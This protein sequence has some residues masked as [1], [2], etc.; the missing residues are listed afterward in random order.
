MKRLVVVLVVA[1][2][3][4]LSSAVMA[5]NSTTHTATTN[6]LGVAST[7]DKACGNPS[8]NRIPMQIPVFP[9]KFCQ[10]M[11]IFPN[12]VTIVGGDSKAQARADGAIKAVLQKWAYPCN[13]SV[14]GGVKPPA[15]SAK[16]SVTLVTD[17]GQSTSTDNH[18]GSDGWS[19][20][21]YRSGSSSHYDSASSSTMGE[22]TF[23]GTS[24]SG[25]LSLVE[26]DGSTIGL[27]MVGDVFSANVERTGSASQ[28]SSSHSYSSSWRRGSDSYHR[29]SSSGSSFRSDPD[30]SKAQSS[31]ITIAEAVEKAVLVVLTQGIDYYNLR[32]HPA[33]APTIE[34]EGGEGQTYAAS[35][36]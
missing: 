5:N 14:C 29:D 23:V 18:S 2:S 33:P 22:S 9:G 28:D 15:G 4:L 17:N 34:S 25:E 16:I 26:S 8:A 21:G 31:R 10:P 19:S 11:Q 12:Q 3:I 13:F 1:F 6:L 35:A 36:Y 30:Y 7:S 27:A 32:Q 20:S 24:V